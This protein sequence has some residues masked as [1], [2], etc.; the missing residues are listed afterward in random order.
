MYLDID[1]T[2]TSFP[3]FGHGA[4]KKFEPIVVWAT[5]Q[6]PFKPMHAP[7]L[8]SESKSYLST[9]C[10]I[11]RMAQSNPSGSRALKSMEPDMAAAVAV[12]RAPAVQ[13]GATVLACQA[14]PSPGRC[15]LGTEFPTHSALCRDRHVLS[16]EGRLKWVDQTEPCVLRTSSHP[17]SASLTEELPRSRTHVKSYLRAGAVVWTEK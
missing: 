1:T 15:S 14:F 3:L 10:M 5:A 16:F 2:R 8:I 17:F 11:P 13:R 6:W 12:R 4:E 9:K 7:G